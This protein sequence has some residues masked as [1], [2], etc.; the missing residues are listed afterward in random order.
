MHFPVMTARVKA[1]EIAGYGAIFGWIQL[2][3]S[4]D[5]ADDDGEVGWKMD[6]IPVLN[7]LDTPF[8]YLGVEPTAFD[9]PVRS[10]PDSTEE[11]KDVDWIAHAFLCVMDDCLLT[12]K[13]KV[14]G[15]FE[16]G[17]GIAYG[18]LQRSG[19]AKR[20][21]V[22]KINV[23]RLT[24]LDD[25]EKSWKDKLEILEVEHTLWEFGQYSPMARPHKALD[26]QR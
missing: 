19:D 14:I 16:W 10:L 5:Q 24:Q 4:T 12:R 25:L 9:A 22:R 21:W 3:R 18:G 8:C 7:T 15:G 11:A 20:K 2:V 1:E 13:V 6:P 26:S 23:K 17:F